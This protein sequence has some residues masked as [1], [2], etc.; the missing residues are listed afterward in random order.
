MRCCIDYGVAYLVQ[1]NYSMPRHPL[2]FRKVS[3]L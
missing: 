2:L 1:P 3:E